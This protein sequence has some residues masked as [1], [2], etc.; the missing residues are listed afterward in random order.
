MSAAAHECWGVPEVEE[1]ARL[2][3]DAGLGQ[4]CS[5]IE[6]ATSAWTGGPGQRE[7]AHIFRAHAGSIGGGV[8]VCNTSTMG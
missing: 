3:L 8:A 5:V 6:P 2:I 1:A 7:T 4:G